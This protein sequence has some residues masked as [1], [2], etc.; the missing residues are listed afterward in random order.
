MKFQH[1]LAILASMAVAGS[2]QAVPVIGTDVFVAGWE[3]SQFQGAGTLVDTAAEA[4]TFTSDGQ[5]ISNFSDLD[6]TQG[7]GSDAGLG[8][9]FYDGSPTNGSSAVGLAFGLDLFASSTS[10]TS[11][12][13]F[14]VNGTPTPE[15]GFNDAAGS[16]VLP[17]EGQNFYN[18]GVLE[19]GSTLIGGAGVVDIVFAVDLTD[20]D[21]LQVGQ[22]WAFQFAG[23]TRGGSDTLVDVEFSTDG[24][25]FVP[26]TTV[27]L[28]ADDRLFG[29]TGNGGIITLPGSSATS[30][31]IRLG[32][33]AGSSQP[34]IDNVAISAD[35]SAIPEPGT[36]LLVAAG[37]GCLGAARRRTA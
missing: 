36:A 6:P 32:F 27:T 14:P 26:V 12:E 1:L 33:D 9:L 13:N 15:I 8:T 7:A 23:Q 34:V 22:N 2:A 18:N 29:P 20:V 5:T 35:L 11:G 10:L 17:G 3:F 24:S 16:T 30:A 31:F 4:G 37:L 21:P 25:T 19:V 28:N